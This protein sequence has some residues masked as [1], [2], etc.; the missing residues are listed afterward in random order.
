MYDHV[1]HAVFEKKFTA[2]KSFGQLLTNRLFD[3]AWAGKSYERARLSKGL[4]S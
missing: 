1:D 2:L 4:K 3:N